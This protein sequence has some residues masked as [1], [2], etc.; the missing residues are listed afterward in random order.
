MPIIQIRLKLNTSKK[1][2]ELLIC[3]DDPHF[4]DEFARFCYLADIKLL[5]SRDDGSYQVYHVKVIA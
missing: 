5:D 4:K 3:A 1:D 2:D